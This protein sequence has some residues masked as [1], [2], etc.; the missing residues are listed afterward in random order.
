MEKYIN[1]GLS[2]DEYY[3]EVEGFSNDGK[4]SGEDQSEAMVEYTRVNFKRMK[5]WRKIYKPSENWL[6]AVNNIQD[7]EDWILI[8]ESWC[9]DAAQSVSQ[10]SNMVD[11]T[12]KLNLKVVYRDENLDLM[13]QFLTNGGRSIPKLIRVNSETKEVIG[14]WGPRV[15]NAQNIVIEGKKNG[16]N[17]GE[18]L[19]TWYAKNK[20]VDLEKEF[21]NLIK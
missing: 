4:A 1:K 5:K 7:K 20:S 6:S 3:K 19:H 11:A 21:V 9:G 17:Y 15:V 2:F 13:D 18:D 14:S 16:T 10:I 12:D 8:T